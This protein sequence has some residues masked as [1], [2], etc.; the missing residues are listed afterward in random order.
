MSRRYSHCRI[1][2]RELLGLI[3]GQAYCAGDT[4]IATGVSKMV[5]VAVLDD[6]H[7]SSLSR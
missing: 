2:C 3:V 5:A 4:T 7:C 6:R 1:H